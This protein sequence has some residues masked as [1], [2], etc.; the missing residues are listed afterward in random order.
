M[1]PDPKGEKNNRNHKP[2][3]CSDG[4]PVKIKTAKGE[5]VIPWPHPDGIYTG[6]THFHP[7]RFL[8][9][10]CSLIEQLVENNSLP[11]AINI[12]KTFNQQVSFNMLRVTRCLRQLLSYF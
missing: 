7:R 2:G 5:L 3:F 12:L 11:L 8:L 6:G 1:Y 10:I 4:A 9:S